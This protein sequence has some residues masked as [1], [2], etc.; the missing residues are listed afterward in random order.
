VWTKTGG[1]LQ[2]VLQQQ[3]G[4]QLTPMR[5]SGRG[6]NRRL[7]LRPGQRL[8]VTFEV[9]GGGPSNLH[10][11]TTKPGYLGDRAVSVIAKT[12]SFRPR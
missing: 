10:F 9:P 2:L 3:P 6:V 11:R 8:T 4:T 7:Q 1:T 5:F 12:L